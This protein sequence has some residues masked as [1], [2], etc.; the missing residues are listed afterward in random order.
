MFISYVVGDSLLDTEDYEKRKEEAM[1]QQKK[2]KKK[3]KEVKE[4]SNVPQS[5]DESTVQKT[6]KGKKRLKNG[7]VNLTLEEESGQKKKKGRT[8]R[9]FEEELRVFK[10]TKECEIETAGKEEDVDETTKK[11]TGPEVIVFEDPAKRKKVR[12][13]I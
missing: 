11:P 5:S 7:N 2:K 3:R 6:K 12:M 13:C 8:L 10:E 9:E 4:L 1:H